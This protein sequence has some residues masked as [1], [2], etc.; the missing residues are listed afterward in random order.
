MSVGVA[1]YNPEAPCSV[2]EL[3]ARADKAMYENKNLK[4]AEED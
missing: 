4:K 3:I 1:F 2:N